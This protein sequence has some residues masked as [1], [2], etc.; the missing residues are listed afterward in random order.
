MSSSFVPYA[1][2]YRTAT[3]TGDCNAIIKSSD[4]KTT[5]KVITAVEF[6]KKYDICLNTL[7]WHVHKKRIVIFKG[8]GRAWLVDMQNSTIPSFK[9]SSSSDDVRDHHL[10]VNVRLREP[11]LQPALD[12]DYFHV[13]IEGENCYFAGSKQVYTAIGKYIGVRPRKDSET[14]PRPLPSGK[15]VKLACKLANGKRHYFSCHPSKLTSAMNE[16]KGKMIGTSKIT[17]VWM[18]S[19]GR[20]V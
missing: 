14:S 18:G 1:Q 16:L 20:M 13:D 17:H 7:K 10:G 4:G 8:R 3:I 6:C 12:K 15:I 5:K 9:K 19:K 11:T 2:K